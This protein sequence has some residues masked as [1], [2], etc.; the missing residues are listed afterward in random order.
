MTWRQRNTAIPAVLG[1]FT[2]LE[3]TARLLVL[4]GLVTSVGSSPEVQQSATQV[5]LDW[6]STLSS[7]EEQVYNIS[8]LLQE[9][10]EVAF[11]KKQSTRVTAP[12]L[13]T[14]AAIVEQESLRTRIA[15]STD[16]RSLLA[17]VCAKALRTTEL[18]KVT[19]KQ[20]AA[21]RL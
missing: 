15:T 8:A 13:H 12:A 3:H 16:G 2:S 5:F 6:A 21:R 18:S 17:D 9:I 4:S 14:L 7:N 20:A 1:I 19:A 11:D 10:Q